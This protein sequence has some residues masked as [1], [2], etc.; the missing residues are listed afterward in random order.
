MD[1]QLNRMQQWLDTAVGGIRFRP[2]RAAVREE[3]QA[4]LEDKAADLQRIFPDS[5]PEEAEKR[6][7][8]E[9][10]DAAELRSALAKIHRPWLGYLWLCSKVLIGVLLVV[11][12]GRTLYTDHYY[13]TG[14]GSQLW[15][16]DDLPQLSEG[17][18]SG[19]T[20]QLVNTYTG[21]EIYT[22]G[23]AP[24]QRFARSYG[25]R[26]DTE[27]NGQTVSLRRAALW[28]GE[29]G[30]E[31]FVWFRVQDWRFWERA[32]LDQEWF[33]VTDSL[34]NRYNV[35]WDRSDC[36]LS[37][38]E[39]GPFFEGWQLYLRDVDP[40]AEWVRVEYGLTKPSFAFT[41]DLERG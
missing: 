25:G 9:M 16:W 5:S 14:T 21:E 39:S 31:L 2:D 3:L 6:A 41:V 22:P 28:Q 18:L 20:G 19:L 33:V 13:S 4:H 15:D 23:S 7:L 17:Y 37:K 32:S 29:Q 40:E 27:V 34:G 8:G 26:Q 12:V 36:V 11:L 30:R 35:D 24:E 1:R 38:S 10:G